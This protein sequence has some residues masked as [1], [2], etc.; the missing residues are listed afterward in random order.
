VATQNEFEAAAGGSELTPE[1]EQAII[2]AMSIEPPEVTAPAYSAPKPKTAE[3]PDALMGAYPNIGDQE[4]AEKIVE[5]SNNLDM[6]PAALAGVIDYETGGSFDPAQRNLAGSGAVGLIQFMGSTARGLLHDAGEEGFAPSEYKQT[7]NF[8]EVKAEDRFRAMGAVEQMDWVERYLEPYKGKLNTVEDVGMA[9]FYPKAIGNPDYNIAADYDRKGPNTG[10]RFRKQNPGIETA[11]DYM[12]KLRGRVATSLSERGLAEEPEKPR[13][14]ETRIAPPGKI[15]DPELAEAL[16]EKLRIQKVRELETQFPLFNEEEIE[17]KADEY[18]KQHRMIPTMEFRGLRAATTRISPI[19]SEPVLSSFAARLHGLREK[20]SEIKATLKDHFDR[21]EYVKGIAAASTIAHT[22]MLPSEGIPLEEMDPELE[23]WTKEGEEKGLEI[24][25]TLPATGLVVGGY[26]GGFTGALLGTGVGALAGAEWN[27]EDRFISD[28]AKRLAYIAEIPALSLKLEKLG[29]RAAASIVDSVVG[30]AETLGVDNPQQY[31]ESARESMEGIAD[32]LEQR[33]QKG[34][35]GTS[36][37]E[38]YIDMFAFGATES[39][40]EGI[41]DA[42]LRVSQ[43]ALSS[44]AG[45]KDIFEER[46]RYIR[47]ARITENVRG[48]YEVA[49]KMKENPDKAEEYQAELVFLMNMLTFS[50]LEDQGLVNAGLDVDGFKSGA[51]DLDSEDVSELQLDVFAPALT[52]A[53]RAVHEDRPNEEIEALLKD[54]PVGTLTHIQPID[55]LM[56][57]MEQMEKWAEEK[58]DIVAKTG[59]TATRQLEGWA[60]RKFHA[61]E[62][63]DGTYYVVESTTGKIFRWAGGIATEAILTPLELAVKAGT[64]FGVVNDPDSLLDIPALYFARI[65]TGEIGVQPRVLDMLKAAGIKPDQPEYLYANL[66]SIAA[67]FLLPFETP[68]ISA[69][70]RAVRV[71]AIQPARGAKLAATGRPYGMGGQGF[72]AGALPSVYKYR[73][74]LRDKDAPTSVH[75]FHKALADTAVAQGKNPFD[76]LPRKVKDNVVEALRVFGVNPDDALR[77]YSQHVADSGSIHDRAVDIAARGETPGDVTMREGE[78]YR[79]FADVLDTFA[80]EGKW[81]ADATPMIRAVFETLAGRLASDP[82]VPNINTPQ[83]FFDNVMRLQEGGEPGPSARFQIDDLPPEALAP[84]K[85]EPGVFEVGIGYTGTRQFFDVPIGDP[86]AKNWIE[87]IK[88]PSAADISRIKAEAARKY[89]ELV[90]D[91]D[92]SFSLRRSYDEEGNAYVWLAYR[93]LHSDIEPVLGPKIGSRMNQTKSHVYRFASDAARA[94]DEAPPRAAPRLPADDDLSPSLASVSDSYTAP[95]EGWTGEVVRKEVGLGDLTVEGAI[96]VMRGIKSGTGLAE[97]IAEN[98]NNP[99]HRQIAQRIMPHLDDTDVHVI[100]GKSENLPQFLLDAEAKGTLQTSVFNDI[101]LLA[102]HESHLRYVSMGYNWSPK[103]DAFN[104]VFLRGVASY[105]GATAETALHELVHAATVRRLYDGNLIA[106]KGTKLQVASTEII[107]LRNKIVRIGKKAQ[108][109]KSLD[110]EL[111]SL[112]IRATQNEKEFVAYGL[113]NKQFQDYLMTIKVD[114]KSL[115]NTFVEKV[116]NLLGISKNNQNVL[117]ELIR[118]T[119]DLLDAPL[120]ALSARVQTEFIFRMGEPVKRLG[121]AGDEAATPPAAAMKLPETPEEIKKAFYEMGRIQRA[122]PESQMVEVGYRDGIQGPITALVEH[123]GDLTHRMGDLAIGSVRGK[124]RKTYDYIY[125]F[126]ETG[127]TVRGLKTVTNDADFHEVLIDEGYRRHVMNSEAPYNPI[128]L[129]TREK[130]VRDL[131][132]QMGLY[133]Q[134]HRTVPVYNEVQRLANDAAIA[135]GERRYIDAKDALGKLQRYLDEGDDAFRARMERIEPEFARP[136]VAEPPA[137]EAPAAAIE[138]VKAVENVGQAQVASNLFSLP[139]GRI[140]VWENSPGAG[141][142]HSIVDFVVDESKRGQGI[143][144]RLVDQVLQAYP[145][146]EISAQVS[147]LASL[148]VLHNKGF[149]HPG[150]E[151]LDFDSLAKLWKDEGGSLNLRR[152][153]EAPA[154]EAPAA[155]IPTDTPEFRTWFGGSKVVD[156]AGE[157]MVV[158][159]GTPGDFDEFDTYGKMAHFGSAGQANIRL[160]DLE[161]R[162]REEAGEAGLWRGRAKGDLG[163]VV[164]VYLSIKNP[165]A[166][167]DIGQ[168]D[169]S[170]K[171]AEE[172]SEIFPDGNAASSLFEIANEAASLRR[173][174]ESF[175]DFAKSADNLELLDEMVD[176]L[177]AEGYDGITYRNLVEKVDWEEGGSAFIAFE[178]T[179]IKSKFNIGTFD[180]DDP[181][182]RYQRRAGRTLGYFEWDE[183]ASKYVIGLFRDGDLNTLWHEQ[184]HLVS[185]IMG[186]KWMDKLVRYFDNEVLPDGTYRLTDIGEEQL[187]DAWMNYMETRFSPS[188]PVK[189]LFE[190]LMWSLKEVWRRLRGKDPAIPPEMRILWDRWLRPDLRGERYAIDVQDAVMRKRHPMVALE[191]TPAE[192]IEAEAVKKAGR[193]REFA[194]VD[195]RPESVRAALGGKMEIVMEDISPDPDVPELVPRRRPVTG[196]V[197]A[198]ELVNNA[199]AY[200]ATEQFKRSIIGEEWVRL[201]LRTHVPKARLANVRNAVRTRLIDAIGVQVNRLKVYQA[202]AALPVEVSE[203]LGAEVGMVARFDNPTME[204]SPTQAAGMKTLVQEIA[205]EPLANIL[206]DELLHPDADFSLMTVQQYNRVLEV[207]IDVESGVA[208]RATRYAE[209]ISP[210]LAHAMINAMKTAANYAIKDIES[211]KVIRDRIKES[212]VVPQFAEGYIDPTVRG[213]IEAGTRELGTIDRWLLQMAD[214]AVKADDATTWR[215]IYQSM[216][217]RLVPPVDPGQTSQL[218]DMVDRFGGVLKAEAGRLDRAELGD[219]DAGYEVAQMT[220]M[221]LYNR[222]DTIQGLLQNSNGLSDMERKALRLLRTYERVP[223]EELSGADLYAI[224]DGIR[225]IHHGL[226]SRRQAVIQRAKEITMALSGTSDKNVLIALQWP[227]YLAVYKRFYRGDFE[228]L[229]DFAGKKGLEVGADPKRIPEYDQSVAVLEMIARMRANELVGQMSR[230]LAEYGVTSDIRQVTDFRKFGPETSLDR[231][232]FIDSVEFYINKEMSWDQNAFLDKQSGRVSPAPA[233]PGG[234]YAIHELPE[235]SGPGRYG[236][237]KTDLLAYTKAHELLAQWGFKLG[238]G[239]WERFEMPDG[240]QTMVPMMV[241]KEIEDAVSR[242]ASVGYAWTG[243]RGRTLRSTRGNVALG[244]PTKKPITVKSQMMLS[245]AF[246]TIMAMNPI[247]ASRIKMGVTTG[248]GVPNPAYY[249]GVSLGALFQAY[250][251]QGVFAAGKYLAKAPITALGV[252]GRRP[253]MVGAVT[254]RMWKEGGYTPHA[255]ALVTKFGQVYTDDMLSRLAIREGMKSSFILA[256]TTQAIARDIE[257]K[258]PQ[259]MGWARKF[260]KWWQN[261]LIEISTAIDNY[262]RVNIFVDELAMGKSPSAAAEVARKAG[263]DYADLTEFE[264]KTMRNVIMFYSYQRKNL[265][266]FW[267]TFLRNPQRLIAQ[268]RLIRGSQRLVLDEDDPMV[269]LPEY[270]HTRL[271]AGSVN[272][273]YNAHFN[274]GMAFV[275]PMLPVEDAIRLLADLYDA[276][277]FEGTERGQD[278]YRGLVSRTTPWVQGPFVLAGERDFYFGHDINR[279][280]VV[281]GWLM[282]LDFNMTGGLLYQ[283]LDVKPTKVK[284]K[285]YEEVPGRLQFVAQNGSNWWLWR[286]MMQMPGAGRSMDTITAMDRANLGPVETM[287]ELANL[288]R[289]FL[290]S[291]LEDAGWLD[292]PKGGRKVT[293]YEELPEEWREETM[294]PRP[295]LYEGDPTDFAILEFLGLMGARP[296]AMKRPYVR[297]GELFERKRYELER[298]TKEME[299]SDVL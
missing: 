153:A 266:L 145:D 192:R 60:K 76:V 101:A 106:N 34:L 83:D 219:L 138:S 54:V 103:G 86:G 142:A 262:F 276:A 208:S 246:D 64:G 125:V 256:E 33:E 200:V 22:G 20:Q 236:I 206:P 156:E 277:A 217:S 84:P 1:Q 298:T 280:N 264:R 243:G 216:I 66:N 154:A 128:P 296:K 98:A 194:R 96:E 91:R 234:T 165:L 176:L 85:I 12:N 110:P 7:R 80:R 263:F 32:R 111:E 289:E 168:W 136:G 226:W 48:V 63:R 287:V 231:D 228:W 251:T 242:A 29:S 17:A 212:F 19:S 222:L 241:I 79:Q 18:V 149:R 108:R 14:E 252:L 27:T 248:I 55:D 38:E 61:V 233:P 67:D 82:D 119:D 281:P 87:V 139:G 36:L 223:I 116:A 11:G 201:T 105:S 123:V 272:S 93:A 65:G 133:A 6:P 178:P 69:I 117:S 100:T 140:K 113:T 121:K 294:L 269:V 46:E 99:V 170:L 250:Q 49:R 182:I 245:K 255:P 240:T 159:H 199:I 190:Q 227:E 57:S 179:Q 21:G 81:D 88:N 257:Q 283:W 114:N 143:G 118:S 68:F 186:N 290:R 77:A 164:P 9:V 271:F 207:L 56:P 51:N 202:G 8:R 104:D 278:A 53:I 78:G 126:D 135:I 183:A 45:R 152:T 235:G 157:P 288:S 109:D 73:H 213:I 193:A 47:G 177:K 115:W 58:V 203:R 137:A 174:F 132:E 253:D 13:F 41:E 220:R 254:A 124:V 214:R 112:L 3:T 92:A 239:K 16:L 160:K 292:A 62:K 297:A 196:E 259:F 218:F 197:D 198:V 237:G 161:L 167:K 155:A 141:G 221:E 260:P 286:N 195:L 244:Q 249:A 166:M 285:A 75:H 74:G 282:E 23:S 284:N 151:R 163:S 230:K 52:K 31:V 181:R 180:P 291:P 130:F 94:A 25:Y 30:A 5:V 247:T 107:E 210:T 158:Y 189:R 10:A 258:M 205:A 120:D 279:N 129:K 188:G 225:E 144:S 71:G 72:L 299:R 95:R 238:K 267:D 28:S 102:A 187:A 172:L 215:S 209:N 265:D 295:D 97:F 211:L 44:E 229:F 261:N 270:M 4:L 127:D 26:L 122:G 185:A 162:N 293:P 24:G 274:S 268:M 232:K 171:L 90:A 184:G 70:G 150:A 89:P 40:R 43:A 224:G 275:L 39:L 191:G 59:G 173:S 42:L 147:S 273:F 134:E 146:K 35:R 37:P 50:D 2:D 175:E 131:E 148:K 204:L 169:S 15:P